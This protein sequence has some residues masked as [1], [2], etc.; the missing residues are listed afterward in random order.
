MSI[1]LSEDELKMKATQYA[2]N[3]SHFS[4]DRIKF[5]ALNVTQ[6]GYLSKWTFAAQDKGET[7]SVYP[8]LI[9]LR[10]NDRGKSVALLMQSSDPVPTL[11][12]NVYE[13][14]ITPPL[15]VRV[16]DFIALDLPSIQRTRLLLSLVTTQESVG[17]GIFTGA[18]DALPL[19]F[20][21]IGIYSIC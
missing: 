1:G 18:V 6:E 5:Q 11:Y 9:V 3:I 21:Q 10:I 4:D 8:A 12:P 14:I 7:G 2:R 16:G 15:L 13:S 19:V 17:A 20:L